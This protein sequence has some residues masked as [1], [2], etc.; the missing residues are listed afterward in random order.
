M[1]KY[2]TCAMISCLILSSAV[3]SSADGTRG[4]GGSGS[5]GSVTYAA[6]IKS[7][8]GPPSDLV[9]DVLA[10]ALFLRWKLSPDDPGTVSGY[11][12]LRA[13]DYWGTYVSIAKV[14]KGVSHYEDKT[15]SPKAIYY[16]R[17]RAIAGSLYSVFSNTAVGDVPSQY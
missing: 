14:E 10:G 16:Y 2:I 3:F 4:E 7:I 6:E 15:V 12:I 17:V 8:P 11:Q 5:P 13:T 1:M 9:L